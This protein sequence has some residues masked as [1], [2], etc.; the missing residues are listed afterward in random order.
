MS[1]DISGVADSSMLHVMSGA[2]TGTPPQQK[3][4]NL[5]NQIDSNGSGSISQDQFDQAFQ[6]LNPPNV[7]KQ[8]G[9]DAI[10]AALDPSGSG[11][12]SKSDFVSGMSQLMVSLR[13]EN[14]T[15]NA[16]GPSPADSLAS[17]LQSLTLLDPA[18]V[19]S[20][21]P[22]GVLLNKTA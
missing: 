14:Q 21:A 22:A 4:T 3:M 11:S 10:F 20:D 1:M 16:P 15:G 12:V 19:P 13:A 5:F 18:S 2:S 6:A 9:P 17:S 8:Q 7:F